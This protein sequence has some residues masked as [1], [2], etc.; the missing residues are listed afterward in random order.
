MSVKTMLITGA[1]RGIGAAT[2]LLA[3]K[4]GYQVAVNYANN[5]A[6][7]QAVVHRIKSLGGKAQAFK[8]DVTNNDE[9]IGLFKAVDAAF[10]GLDVLV[11]N[12]GIL[13]T[14]GILQATP[15]KISR[16]FEANLFSLYYCSREAVKR[17]ST[18]QGGRGG[19]II[20]MSSAAAKLCS[21]PGGN[22]YSASKAAVDG[23]NLALANEVGAQGIRVNAIRPGLIATD[24]QNGR[25]GL[26]VAAKIA[27]TSVPMK[28]M[29]EPS[30]I[31]EAVIWL[32]SE[33]AS[34]V[35]G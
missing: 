14:F 12:A 22:A 17:M 26:E 30:E 21:M 18:E 19:V 24:I 3:G 11:N 25:G 28:R 29:G 32:A 10:G 15:D 31:A 20:N 1:S 33:H 9:V 27:S 7:A 13:E 8:A 16:T 2:A 5:D 23:F 4:H 35:H 34:Y 6:A